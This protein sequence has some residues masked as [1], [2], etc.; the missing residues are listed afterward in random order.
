MV[1]FG[2]SYLPLPP[3]R[4]AAGTEDEDLSKCSSMS[5]CSRRNRSGGGGSDRTKPNK[6]KI[7]EQ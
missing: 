3:P 5:K 2:L 6:L 7:E 4:C 1:K